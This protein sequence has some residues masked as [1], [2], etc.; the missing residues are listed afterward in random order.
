MNAATVGGHCLDAAYPIEVLHTGSVKR[1]V[2]NTA[3]GGK[4]VVVVFPLELDDSVLFDM[5]TSAFG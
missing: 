2:F 4:I 3:S 1:T 5:S